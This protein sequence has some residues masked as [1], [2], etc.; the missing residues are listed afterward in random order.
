MLAVV[1]LHACA[2]AMRLPVPGLVW[3]VFVPAQSWVCDWVFWCSRCVASRA[4]SLVAGFVAASILT[5]ALHQGS[6]LSGPAFASLAKARLARLAQPL[7]LGVLLVLPAMY[8]IWS[9]GWV[10]FG[11][12]TWP[13]VLEASFGPAVG[14]H[15]AGL[16]HL[17]FLPACML[18]TLLLF[19]LARVRIARTLLGPL[20]PLLASPWRVV[21]LVPLGAAVFHWLPSSLTIFQNGFVPAPGQYLL[22]LL[23]FA[24]GA[25]LCVCG[26][27]LAHCTRWWVAELAV[28]IAALA[29]CT[30]MIFATL[31]APLDAS[32]PPSAWYL[33][34][35]LPVP[36]LSWQASLLTSLAAWCVLLGTLGACVRVGQR[37]RPPLSQLVHWLV[38]RQ[39]WVYLAHLPCVGLAWALLYRAPLESEA[40]A[41]IAFACGLAGPLLLHALWSRARAMFT[42]PEP[43]SRALPPPQRKT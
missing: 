33:S 18:S 1:L 8:L 9:F 28:G 10:R 19:A 11:F 27:S 4:F 39:L 24:L 23:C 25:G 14:P 26:Q 21:F 3:P 16:A 36:S 32:Q 17:W 5:K 2:P 34:R 12:A 15:F 30:P 38:G 37:L 22:H 41:C 29:F 40:K 13:K 20:A 7:A 31:H 35:S 42:P 6:P 43:S